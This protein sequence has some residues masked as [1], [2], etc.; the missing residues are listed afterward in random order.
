MPELFEP[1]FTATGIGTLPLVDPQTA[2]AAITGRLTEMPYWPQ[3]PRRDAMEDMSLQYAHALR[4]LVAPDTAE[5]M[6]RPHPGL[7]REEALAGFYERLFTSETAD[8]GLRPEEAAGFFAFIAAIGRADADAFPWIKGHVT[9]PLTL[10]AS[11]I[12]ADGK[13]MLYDDE[14][15]EALAKGLGAAAA[16][17]VGQ[18]A[19]L[20]RPAL[21]F[22][23][24]PFLSG[25]G[26][27][28]SPIS[29]DQAINL[30]SLTLDEARARSEAVWGVHC[31]GNTDW[32]L[33]IDA[34]FDVLNLDSAGFGRH[35]LLYPEAL[36]RFYGRGG[37]V[38]WGA[39]PTIGYTGA[40]TPASL[41]AEL[42]ALLTDLAKL[43]ID[44]AV[45]AN[46]AL[47]S[48]ACGL[49]TLDEAKTLAILDLTRGVSELA[50][51]DFL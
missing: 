12:G 27:A 10:A 36:K 19:D 33:L 13:A 26:S 18:L 30:L 31:C 38:A 2:V 39:V 47:V 15:A 43:G 25:Y 32:S 23:D 1:R 22:I 8:F 6:L 4:P 21:I 20:G 51:E 16:A 40:E 49:G 17:Q 28:F 7:S 29:R 44:R 3:L 24:E 5:R 42:K 45:I 35:L 50:R 34:G 11:A 48:P 37:A 46:Q 41:W 14:M 9:G